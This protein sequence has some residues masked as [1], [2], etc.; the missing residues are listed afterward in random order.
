MMNTSTPVTNYTAKEDSDETA[1]IPV[2]LQFVDDQI[3]RLELNVSALSNRLT[4]I[5]R[6]ELDNIG[7][8]VDSVQRHTE[9][10]VHAETL[11]DFGH[12]LIKANKEIEG[13]L[14]KLEL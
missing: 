10:C 6:Q 12:R 11:C 14:Q 13:M 9:A 8:G 5:T 4:T 2:N 1:S 3:C 7:G